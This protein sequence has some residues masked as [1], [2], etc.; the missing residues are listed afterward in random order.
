M[1]SKPYIIGMASILT[2]NMDLETGIFKSKM[3]LYIFQNTFN[4]KRKK[5]MVSI[6]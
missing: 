2:T 5:G 3:F 4:D 6:V 1:N